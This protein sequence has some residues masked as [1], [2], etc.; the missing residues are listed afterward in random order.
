MSLK[1]VS[2]SEQI[3][4]HLAEQI[5]TGQLAPGERLP[6][7][8]LARK[9]DV[10]T[11]SL[12]EAFRLLEKQHLIKLQPRKGAWVCEVNEA[13]VRDLYSFLFLL[14]STLAG[15]A[16][17]NWRHGEIEDLVNMLPSLEQHYHNG[18]ILSAHQLAFQLVERA[19][20]RFAGN[21]YLAADIKNLIPL[22]K[23]FSYMALQ[24]ET[25]EF[26]VS[27]QIFK[28]LLMHVVARDEAAAK[29]D[30]REYGDNQCKIVLHAINKQSAEQALEKLA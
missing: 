17:K 15:Q 7:I 11:N 4:Q 8:E 10:S 24:K 28:R 23:R 30:I 18:D 12:R 1:A 22:L 25:T 6:E 14:L 13:Q 26:D 21:R 29:A 9:L 5:I 27:L 19:V 16:A 20:E 3:A 2:L